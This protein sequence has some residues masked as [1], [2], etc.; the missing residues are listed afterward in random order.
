MIAYRKGTTTNFL[1]V[2]THPLRAPLSSELTEANS[3]SLSNLYHFY[4]PSLRLHPFD[5]ADGQPQVSTA[6]ASTAVRTSLLATASVCSHPVRA[7]QNNSATG[8]RS[9]A[10]TSIRFE[11]PPCEAAVS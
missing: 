5:E 11:V 10:C 3:S 2:S 4:G 1:Y 6:R 7:V 8:S 9:S